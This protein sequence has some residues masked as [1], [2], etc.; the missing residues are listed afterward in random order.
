MED[1]QARILSG[2]NRIREIE[3]DME[4]SISATKMFELQ[5]EKSNLERLIADHVLNYVEL[6][7]LAAQDKEPNS[8][9]IIET[10][11]AGKDPIR[12]RVNLNILLSSGL[13][14]LLA[15]SIIF[16]WEFLDD[17]VKSTDDLSQFEK[18]NILGAIGRI[19]G[20]KYSGKIAA[21]MESYRMIRNKIRLGSADNPA[22]S[23]VVTS[24]EPGEG[25][26]VTAANLGVIMAQANIKTVIVDA[27]LRHPVQHKM[28]DVK[29][30]S[31]LMDLLSSPKTDIRDCLKSTSINNLQI[32]TSGESNQDQS[33]QLNASRKFSTS[34]RRSL[35]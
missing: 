6:L 23:I 10:A 22:K 21:Q 2:Q 32:M 16:L 4:D 17:T 15:L 25:K 29:I 27:D 33:E 35:M 20:Q 13:G 8:L 11:Q 19:K 24:P 7:N 34:L 30:K 28:F 1:T 5:T 31:G 12:P 3:A 18:L 26:S 9:S 14:M